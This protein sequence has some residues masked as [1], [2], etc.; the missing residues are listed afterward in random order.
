MGGSPRC[1]VCWT[2]PKTAHVIQDGRVG[3]ETASGSPK[4]IQTTHPWQ[5][6]VAKPCSSL[7]AWWQ[8]RS[9]VLSMRSRTASGFD[10]GGLFSGEC[11]S[12]W[13]MHWNRVCDFPAA[14]SSSCQQTST[15]R[16]S[17]FRS[18]FDR[19]RTPNFCYCWGSGAGI[20]RSSG[21]SSQAGVGQNRVLQG[22]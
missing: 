18:P 8:R 20:F 16:L 6:M 12:G 22:R 10:L 14:S 1:S 9:R 4:S 13:G 19:L 2:P 7:D 17:G 11:W 15:L 21:A 3:V 5:S